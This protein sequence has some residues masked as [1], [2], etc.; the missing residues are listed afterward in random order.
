MSIRKIAALAVL[1]SSATAAFAAGYPEK[2]VRIVVPYAPGG[3]VDVVARKVAQKLSE[4]TGQTFYVENKPGG[5][6]LIGTQSVARSAPDGYTLLAIDN[7]YSVL[8]YV[9]KS[10][11]WDHAKAFTPI[12][13]SMFAPVVLAVNAESQFKDLGT[14][15]GQAR[16]NPG[17]LTYG[18]GGAGSAPHFAGEAFALAAN[19]KLT[20]IPYKGAGDAMTGLMSNQI[21][22]L[23]VST[24]SA[25]AQIKAGKIRALAVSGS[26]R[27]SA[28]PSVPTFGEAG[29]KDFSVVNWNGLAAPAGTPEP[30]VQKL[31]AEMTKV[32][33]A[34]DF[35][36][37][38]ASLSAEPG[39]NE[40][41]AFAALIREETA[42]WE[43]VSKNAAIE[44]Q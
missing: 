14:L 39:G 25:G 38:L 27:L 2:P 32:L 21:D 35:K 37:F 42:R 43:A 8:P 18:S 11:P 15:L 30:I 36:E 16:A 22:A 31:Y 9:F 29:L 1:L 20:H 12:T 5:T 10:L 28:L 13:V 6:G 3:A 26:K 17:K 4:Q 19:V 33:Q 40:P 23:L 44:K 41:K 34:P 24:P 7:T